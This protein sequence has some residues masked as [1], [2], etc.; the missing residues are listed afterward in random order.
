MS[1]KG[2]VVGAAAQIA[3]PRNVILLILP[4]RF[5]NRLMRLWIYNGSRDLLQLAA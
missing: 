3:N 5:I 2:G 4:P 1:N